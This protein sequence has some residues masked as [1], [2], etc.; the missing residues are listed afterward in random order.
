MCTQAGMLEFSKT[1]VALGGGQMVEVYVA[2][3][4]KQGKGGW[5]LLGKDVG[6][7]YRTWGRKCVASKSYPVMQIRV[8]QVIRVPLCTG[9]KKAL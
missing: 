4:A 9:R 1:N 6:A 3:Q 2:S 7:S 8:S 5:G